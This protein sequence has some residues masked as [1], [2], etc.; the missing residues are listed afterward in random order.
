MPIRLRSNKD[1]DVFLRCRTYSHAWDE[2]TPIDM[3]SPSYGWRLSL[4]CV[5]CGTERH[6]TIAYGT[7]QVNGRQYIYVEGYQYIGE[8]KPT[9]RGLPS[10]KLSL[11]QVAAPN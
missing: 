4:R 5:R 2:F 3:E 1:G 9:K 6:D 7:G 10:K 8:D 11:L